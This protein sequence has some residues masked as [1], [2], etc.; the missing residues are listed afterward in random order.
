MEGGG[1]KMMEG[2]KGRR[3]RGGRKRERGERER[4]LVSSM[5]G[6]FLSLSLFCSNSCYNIVI[7]NCSCSLALCRH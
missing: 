6:S 1:R 4:E 5:I 2:G 7:I 3:E